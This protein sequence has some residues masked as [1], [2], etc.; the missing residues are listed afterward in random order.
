[1][2]SGF[3][4]IL[5]TESGKSKCDVLEHPLIKTTKHERIT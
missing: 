3:F 1:M 5:T 2:I 4:F